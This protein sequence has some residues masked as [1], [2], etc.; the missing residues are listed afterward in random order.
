MLSQTITPDLP[1][2]RLTL[3]GVQQYLAHQGFSLAQA[4]VAG[5]LLLYKQVVMRAYVLSFQDCFVVGAAIC[6]CGVVPALLLHTPRVARHLPHGPVEEEA[7][8]AVML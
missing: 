5:V 8:E 7:I 2:V 4:K 3:A 6:L 1:G